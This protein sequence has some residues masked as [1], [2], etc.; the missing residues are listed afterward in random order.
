MQAAVMAVCTALEE[1]E[2]HLTEL[3][4]VTGDGD[5]GTSLTRGTKAIQ[6]AL[7]SYPLNQPAETLKAIALTLQESMGGSS[8]P[9]YAIFL[10]RAAQ[11]LGQA[12]MDDPLRWATAMLA[13]CDGIFELGGATVGDRTMLDA[14]VPFAQAL[15]EGLEQGRSEAEAMK[16]AADRS[17]AAALD[18]AHLAAR[19]GRSSYLGGR[20]LGTPDPGAMAAA[21]WL[22]AIASWWLGEE[23]E[24]RG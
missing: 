3:D 14:L 11:A 2:A 13:G 23:M 15:K 21:I 5:L 22:R 16:A 18:S 12:G 4:R 9:L 19:R 1:A 17:E 8:G 20:E 10:L 6:A 7:P 24:G